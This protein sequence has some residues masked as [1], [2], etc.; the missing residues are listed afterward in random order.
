MRV[1]KKYTF[2]LFLIHWVIKGD[3]GDLIDY[4]FQENISLDVIQ[5]GLIIAGGGL[6]FSPPEF[7]ISTY[8]IRYESQKPDGNL[9]T[10]SGLVAIPNSTT[11][12]FPILSY[13]HGTGILDTDAPSI[14]GLS[15]FNVEILAVGF[16]A[17]SS[18][19][20]TIFPDY[21]GMANPNVYHPYHIKD[22]Y[23]RAVLHMIRAVKQLSQ[24]LINEGSFQY[25]DQLF[26]AGYS[27]GGYATLAAQAGIEQLNNEEFHI[28][29]SFPMAGAYDLAGTM[30]DYFLSEPE[31]ENPYYVPY[32]LTSHVWYYQGIN[33]DLN[34][35]FEPYWA[36]TLP[37]LYNGTFSGAQINNMLPDNVLDILIDDDHFLRQT[38]SQ[39]TLLDWVPNSPT[40]LYHGLAD[41]QVP[42]EN[43]V[44]AY[45]TFQSN[46]ASNVVLELLPESAGGHTSAAI[47]SIISGYNL[48]TEYMMINQKGDMD[49]DGDVT[50]ID[51][52]YLS[53][54]IINDL[55][56]TDFQFWLANL[57]YDSEINVIDI[58]MISDIAVSG[59]F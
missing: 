22:S 50:L 49:G 9:D 24:T 41:D 31:Y 21:V 59:G 47:P 16:L 13:Q 30:V 29:A 39:N 33:T 15:L 43:S 37:D 32:V 19:F 35:Y 12:A 44:V 46:G 57:N 11:Q 3:P 4:N 56:S 52:A 55:Y 34:I 14:T 36:E 20:I 48:M 42:H 7:T 1:F 6:G 45:N 54:M 17:T 51:Q 53:A 27:E 28:T 5:T 25:N 18:G 8:D 2:I 58:L 26:L 10:L 23:V 40:Y 38:L